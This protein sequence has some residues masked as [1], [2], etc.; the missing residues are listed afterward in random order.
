MKHAILIYE[1]ETDF[2]SRTDANHES[3]WAGWNAYMK[4]LNEAGVLTGG[5]PLH[6]GDKGTTVKVRNGS[7]QV[8]DG[9]YSDTKEQLGGFLILE[10]PSIDE[11]LQWAERCPAAV[12][13]AVEVRPVLDMSSGG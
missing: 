3:Y 8:H 4:A 12:S 2:R 9:P 7:R 11:A 10:V 5:Q 6:G 1:N 13:G